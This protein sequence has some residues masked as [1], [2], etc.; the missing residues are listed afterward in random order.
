MHLGQDQQGASL[1]YG[2]QVI[3]TE[4]EGSST[5]EHEKHKNELY[6]TQISHWLLL[7]SNSSQ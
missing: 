5:N 4:S 3:S 2:A 6:L 7:G 1:L